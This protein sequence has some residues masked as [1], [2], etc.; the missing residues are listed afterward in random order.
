MNCKKIIPLLLLS[1][2]AFSLALENHK[3][4]VHGTVSLDVAVDESSVLIM[5]KTPAQ[6]ILGF[7]K[8]IETAQEKAEVKK[9]Q[10]LWT[11]GY[12][13]FISFEGIEKCKPQD[14]S[15]KLEGAGKEHSEVK[16][17]MTLVCPFKI[18][19]ILKFDLKKYSSSILQSHYQYL[20][21]NN[22]TDSGT[23]KKDQPIILKTK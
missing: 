1:L 11:E 5:L 10:T 9:Y 6:S 15:W 20:G 22:I 12:K 16:A 18:E 14:I 8:K 21:P 23:V 19:V 7:E 3:P 17:E 13:T 2:P 4:H